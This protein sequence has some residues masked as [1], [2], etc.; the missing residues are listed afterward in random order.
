MIGL[1]ECHS[2][3]HP[4]PTRFEFKLDSEEDTQILATQFAQFINEYRLDGEL[5]AP[6]I[7]P[8]LGDL[9]AGKTTFS[10]FVI[11]ALSCSDEVVPSPTFSLVNQYANGIFH[12]D[13]YRLTDEQELDYLGIR[14]ELRA[15][16]IFLI[17]WADLFLDY[18]GD[19][20]VEIHF[21]NNQSMRIRFII[22]PS[23]ALKLNDLQKKLCKY[24]KNLKQ[25]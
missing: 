10:R 15:G 8:L 18:F 19:R 9:G 21:V 16:R 4:I 20:L 25:I 13:C 11:Q 3:S 5:N 17:E 14:D 12:I 1:G 24:I 2:V 7:I 6:I 23:K 22:Y